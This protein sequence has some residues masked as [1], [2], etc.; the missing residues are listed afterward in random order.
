M[1]RLPRAI[2]VTN[3]SGALVRARPPLFG[4]A[5]PDDFFVAYQNAFGRAFPVDLLPAGPLRVVG[6][7]RGRRFAREEAPEL[8]RAGLPPRHTERMQLLI[9]ASR[10]PQYWHGKFSR[11]D[12][13]RD[14]PVGYF[15]AGFDRNWMGLLRFY[16]LRCDA[17]SRVL[18][19]LPCRGASPHDSKNPSGVP[20]FLD[21]FAAFSCAVRPRVDALV[22]CEKSNNTLG[23]LYEITMLDGT[24]RRSE[25]PQFHEENFVDLAVRLMGD[26][27]Q[28]IS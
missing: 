16:Y 23:S 1:A 19:R 17:W 15:L 2:V 13:M 3:L 9:G 24:T 22:A 5:K 21:A 11:R 27:P 26:E 10:N 20:D 25:Q 12:F 18:F 7:R 4:A 14:C 6:D 8:R 28:R